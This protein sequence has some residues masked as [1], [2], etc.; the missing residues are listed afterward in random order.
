LVNERRSLLKGALAAGTLWSLTGRAMAAR[1][2]RTLDLDARSAQDDLLIWARLKADLAGRTLYSVT[3]GTVWGFK[4]QA[5]DLALQDFARRLYGYTTCVARRAQLRA[6]GS[7][8]I[9]AQSWNFYL[10]PDTHRF[11]R[12]I[13]NPYTDRM[14]ASA[15]MLAPAREQVFTVAGAAAA[16]GAATAET[17]Q[18]ARP[19]DLQ[20][21]TVGEHAFVTESSFSRFK[22]G[23]IS[24]YKLE[25]NMTSHACLLRDVRDVARTHVPSTWAQNLVAEW[26]TWMEMHGTPGHI[27]FKG[28]GCHV[29]RVAE[30]SDELRRD[31]E[32]VTPGALAETVRWR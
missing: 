12:E 8:V 19:F 1:A 4:P 7:V 23:N 21:R 14:V 6:D 31:I 13:H 5:D 26:Q 32:S 11:V 9:R 10:H 29:A 15:P 17:L 27:L 20:I 28:D 22:S 2:R 25:G 3:T 30:L 18:P 24:W 16:A